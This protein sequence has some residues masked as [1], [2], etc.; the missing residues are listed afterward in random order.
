MR[1]NILGG[2]VRLLFRSLSLT[3][4]PHHDLIEAWRSILRDLSA[5]NTKI[6]PM[7]APT[8]AQWYGLK[9]SISTGGGFP[10]PKTGYIEGG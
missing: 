1:I 6:N 5:R 7:I 3:I 4:K 2:F 8:I 9:P 10:Y